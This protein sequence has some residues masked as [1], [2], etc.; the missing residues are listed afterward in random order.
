MLTPGPTQTLALCPSLHKYHFIINNKYLLV[1]TGFWVT[2]VTLSP[3]LY[4]VSLTQLKEAIVRLFTSMRQ[5]K[6]SVAHPGTK[7][8]ATIDQ[9]CVYKIDSSNYHH[10]SQCPTNL[11]E[12]NV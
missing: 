11:A 3:F 2:Y 8:T 9:K 12:I 7:T 4:I 5:N 6:T 1:S 10:R